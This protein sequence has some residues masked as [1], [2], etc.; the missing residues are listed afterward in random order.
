MNPTVIDETAEPADAAR[1]FPHLE[2]VRH[3]FVETPRLRVHIA[4]AGEGEP[5][6]LLLHG[7]PQHWYAWRKVIPLLAEL[8][9]PHLPRSAWLRLDRRAPGW[10]TGTAELADDLLALL[11][12]IGPRPGARRRPRPRRSA[13]LRPLPTRALARAPA[14]DA[15]RD[16]SLLEREAAGATSVAVLVDCLRGDAAHRTDRAA[17]NPC[18]HEDAL[19]ARHPQPRNPVRVRG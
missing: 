12:T 15:Q 19:P 18:F 8:P 2:G 14:G 13:R 17:A 16:A 3:R 5:P 1:A 6:L 4:E 11:D 10:A 7:W 9:S